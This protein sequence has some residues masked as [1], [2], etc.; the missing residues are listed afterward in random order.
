[1]PTSQTLKQI[2]LAVLVGS[3]VT[4]LTSLAQALLG[5][6]NGDLDSVVGGLVAAAACNKSVIEHFK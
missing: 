5:W 4:F 2:L 3:L 6:L 1:M